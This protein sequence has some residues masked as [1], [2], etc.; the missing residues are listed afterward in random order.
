MR[1]IVKSRITKVYAQ[2]CIETF[3]VCFLI[4][5]GF[6]SATLCYLLGNLKNNNERIVHNIVTASISLSFVMFLGILAYHVHLRIRKMK[7]Y[8]VFLERKWQRQRQTATCDPEGFDSTN[9]NTKPLI[10][11]TTI[12]LGERLLESTD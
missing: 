11:T 9:V 12:E 3:E 2:V 1:L 7:Y 10:T 4:N 8:T 6:L 5:L